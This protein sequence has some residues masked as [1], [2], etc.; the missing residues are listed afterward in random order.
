MAGRISWSA[1]SG[2]AYLLFSETRADPIAPDG[3]RY[4][5]LTCSGKFLPSA[6]PFTPGAAVAVA[7]RNTH[8][9]RGRLGRKSRKIGLAAASVQ[10]LAVV[11]AAFTSA[12]HAE[13]AER[14]RSESCF[15]G[16]LFYA[17]ASHSQALFRD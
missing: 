17:P 12:R 6:D 14:P 3:D 7:G 15:F 2:K 13:I 9:D 11:L 16:S 10:I 1:V 8:P 5:Y 4:P